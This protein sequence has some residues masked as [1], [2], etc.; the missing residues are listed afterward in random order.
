MKIK[1]LSY[2]IVFVAAFLLLVYSELAA[3]DESRTVIGPRNSMLADGADALIAGD[4]EEGV[5]LT[6]RGLALALG[7]REKKIGHANL[8]AG[9]ER[10]MNVLKNGALRWNSLRHTLH[11]VNILGHV[12]LS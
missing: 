2:W 3:D 7:E 1:H 6:L 8:C 11:G 12:I 4:G 5:R 10:E 9:K